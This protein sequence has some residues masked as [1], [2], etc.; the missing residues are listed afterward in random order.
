MNDSIFTFLKISYKN[1]KLLINKLSK[2]EYWSKVFHFNHSSYSDED[3]IR[4]LD[5]DELA[6]LELRDPRAMS[7]KE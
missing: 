6:D 2:T 5:N 4:A 3:Y 7:L 1:N